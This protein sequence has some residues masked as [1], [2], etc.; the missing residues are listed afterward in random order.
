VKASPLCEKPLHT[1]LYKREPR[2]HCGILAR[3]FDMKPVTAPLI[4]LQFSNLNHGSEKTRQSLDYPNTHARCRRLLASRS[5][6]VRHFPTHH[7]L[8]Q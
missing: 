7:R 2:T 1:V 5:S 3:L 8:C 4:V 6:C